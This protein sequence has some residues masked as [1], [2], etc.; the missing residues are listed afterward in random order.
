MCG[1][2][3]DLVFVFLRKNYQLLLFA[4]LHNDHRVTW[5]DVGLL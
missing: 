5:F 1:P 4:S 2:Y 3:S